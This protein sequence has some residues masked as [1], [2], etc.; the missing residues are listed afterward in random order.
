MKTIKKKILIYGY[1]FALGCLL[2][3][4]T[5][6]QLVVDANGSVGVGYTTGIPPFTGKLDVQVGAANVNLY[7]AYLRNLNAT[8]STKYGVYN[9]V[10]NAGAGGRFGIY[11]D[12]Q[13]NA[14]ATGSAYGFYNYVNAGNSFAAG[15]YSTLTS[16]GTATLYGHINFSF[17]NGT[18]TNSNIGLYN[19]STHNN[20][21]G[22]GIYNYT[23]YGATTSTG[24]GYGVQNY[25][26][27]YSSGTS[28]GIYNQVQVPATT[29]TGARYGIYNQVDNIGTGIKYGIYSSAP[30]TTN[31]AGYFNGNVHIQGNFTVISDDDLKTD[32]VDIPNSLDKVKRLRAVNFKFKQDAGFDLPEELQYGFLASNVEMVAPEIVFR[33][34]TPVKNTADPLSG[35][36]VEDGKKTDEVRLTEEKPKDYRT[37][38][39]IGVI[40]LLVQAVK[41][42]SG[43]AQAQ[44]A[45]IQE[46]ETTIQKMKT[47]TVTVK[48]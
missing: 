36:N 8:N 48:Q 44:S 22:R 7:S 3:P 14:T 24:I 5:F 25:L 16:S 29:V 32:I 42:L 26:Y 1:V 17:K 37:I 21:M 46:L 38:N 2:S 18:N 45:R 12:V 6:A 31:Y 23:Y 15:Q 41:E 20:N 40:P 34:T 47:A 33:N 39:Y 10:S 30:G 27:S 4:G 11:N 13:Q 9:Q 28:Y 19:Y 35:Y 43:A